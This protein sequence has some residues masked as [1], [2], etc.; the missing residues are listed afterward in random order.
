MSEIAKTIAA[1]VDRGLSP[2]LKQ[3]GFRKRGA[4]YYRSEGDS[5]QVVTVQSSQWNQS[6]A[7][8]FR[9]NFGVHFPA[10]AVALL[11]EDN[12]PEVPKE[13]YCLLRAIWGS[14]DRWWDVEPNTDVAVLAATIRAYGQ[15]VVCPW[16]EK[17]KTLAEAARTLETEPWGPSP[18]AAAARLVLGE[19]DKAEH[20]MRTYLANLETSLATADP[21]NIKIITEQLDTMRK[22]AA[23]QRLL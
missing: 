11:G 15:D 21:A 1:V 22:W 5:I 9:L 2:L 14:P 4:H 16:L 23:K 3:R 19:R 7:G 12:M 18:A 20:I 8:K 10:V 13:H 6:D 17:N